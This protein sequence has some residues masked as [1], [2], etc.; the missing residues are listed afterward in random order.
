MLYNIHLINE[1]INRRCKLKS[2]NDFIYDLDSIIINEN[3]IHVKSINIT[4]AI[5]FYFLFRKD[6]IDIYNELNKY[7][8]NILFP[9]SNLYSITRKISVNINALILVLFL[10]N[11]KTYDYILNYIKKLLLSTWN[12][13]LYHNPNNK[14]MIIECGTTYLNN[15][16]L[17][18]CAKMVIDN[19]LS[20]IIDLSLLPDMNI[21]NELFNKYAVEEEIKRQPQNDGSIIEY[22]ILLSF[23]SSDELK[24]FI[25]NNIDVY[26]ENNEIFKIA[27]IKKELD[28]VVG[29]FENDTLYIDS[30]YDVKRSARLIF[31][32]IEKFNAIL[33]TKF[34]FKLKNKFYKT[35]FNKNYKKGYLYIYD[36]NVYDETI[37]LFRS[38]LM[39]YIDQYISSNDDIIEF[40][41]IFISSNSIR[42]NDHMKDFLI[43][44]INQLNI[45]NMDKIADFEIRQ[46]F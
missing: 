38:L 14:I 29:T 16:K 41:K 15:K 25:L 8:Y 39:K 13:I 12:S 22:N 7:I 4:S 45:L 6:K 34:N 19:F 21:I 30:V 42:I 40:S 33:D 18:H 46:C 17:E 44:E 43:N 27:N 2:A 9:K 23:L 35:S 10:R 31:N 36:W 37:Y 32:D 5:L 28:I 11:I 1:N 26:D 24:D 20:S 3:Y